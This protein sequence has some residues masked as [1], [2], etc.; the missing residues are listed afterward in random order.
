MKTTTTKNNSKVN[1]EKE[2]YLQ[3]II[4]KNN[5]FQTACVNG[6]VSGS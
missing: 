2:Q 6:C 3:M 4:K 1:T 5:S